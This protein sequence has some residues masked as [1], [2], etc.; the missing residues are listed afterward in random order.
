MTEL[1]LKIY[2]YL[3][4]HRLSGICSSVAITLILLLAVT[5][6]NYKEDIADFLPIDSEHQN[7]MKVYQNISGASKIFAIF[8]YRN[9]AQSDDPEILTHTIDAFVENVEKADSA[10]VIRNLMAQVDLEK[11]NQITD[12]VYQNIPYFLTDAD[13]RRMDSLLSQPD[14]IPHQL[15]ADKQML[16]FPTGGILSDNIQRD[17]LNLF[18]PILQKLQHSESSLKYEMYDGYIFS[19]DMK[20]AIVMMDSPFGESETENN[21]RLTQMLKDCAREASQS[22]PNIEIHIIGGPVI[23]VTNAHQIKTDSILSVSIAV[24]LILALLFFSFRSRRNLLLIA[25]SIGW[26]WLFAIGGLA[27]FH[28]QVSVIVIGISSIILGIAVNYPLHFIAH[29]S[30]TPDK[31]KALKEIV[32]PLL[33][34]N[35]TT[36]GAFLALVPLKSVALRDL[37][38]FSSL[39]LVGT[40]VFVLI[41]LPHLSKTTGE[42]KHTFLDKWSNIS[43]EKKPIFVTIVLILTIIFGYFSLQTEFDTNMAHINYMTPEQKADMEYFA[44]MMKQEDGI[45]KVYALSSDSTLDGALDKSLSLQGTLQELSDQKTIQDYSSCNQFITSKKE[46]ARRLQLWQ[47]FL[48]KHQHLLTSGIKPYMTEEGF[49]DG[50]FADF[51]HILHQDYQQQDIQH[52]KPLLQSAFASNISTDSLNGKYHVINILSTKEKD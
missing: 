23:A 52:F 40:I 27:L 7:A 8:Q 21:A 3:K 33:V 9:A 49:A 4:T 2:D 45:Q 11:M 37:G 42:A 47:K 20:K 5:R 34:G 16:L 22:Q 39:L 13:Y 32:M 29:L 26:G 10:H 17:P 50:C 36:V 51:E 31:R 43:L 38:L 30:H 24:V 35:V 12:F 28:N 1:I 19:P 6:L 25:L 44:K 41:Y 14:Y 15:K 48:D 18:T 46:Q